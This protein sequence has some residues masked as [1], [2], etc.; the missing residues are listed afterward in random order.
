MLLLSCPR[1]L[2]LCGHWTQ[3]PGAAPCRGGGGHRGASW[4]LVQERASCLP[5]LFQNGTGRPGGWRLSQRGVDAGWPHAGGTGQGFPRLMEYDGRNTDLPG[6]ELCRIL[7]H[8]LSGLRLWGWGGFPA[9]VGLRAG[10]GQSG[11]GLGWGDV[12]VSGQ[13]PHPGAPRVMGSSSTG[14][15]GRGLMPGS[16]LATE[17]PLSVRQTFWG[18]KSSLPGCPVWQERRI[19]FWGDT[20]C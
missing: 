14:G 12:R 18:S 19:P 6:L 5:N 16:G 15:G 2:S 20:A 9:L 7:R 1:G 11:H 10:G 8:G 13:P 3:S 4:S 17:L